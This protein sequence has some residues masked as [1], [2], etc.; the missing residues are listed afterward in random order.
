V[1]NTKGFTTAFATFSPFKAA[2][3][4]YRSFFTLALAPL[5]TV[6]ARKL[7]FLHTAQF[8]RLAPKHLRR[9]GLTGPSLK[10]GALL[11]ISAFNGDAE[12]YFRAFGQELDPVMNR[13]WRDCAEWTGA[14]PYPRLAAFI[15][16]FRRRSS[17]FFNAYPAASKQLR[18]SLIL[19][20][21]L[22]KLHALALS[23]A[24]DEQFKAA[25]DHTAQL[26]WG[27]ARA[28][29]ADL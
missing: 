13:V 3:N 15:G 27:N 1:D 6:E 14:Q 5:L 24:S 20:R 19:R 11:F 8:I 28:T 23:D 10:P 25:F 4:R 7:A 29:G 17:F 16:S 2:K 22:D 18:A 21:Q 26:Q 12:T 9:A